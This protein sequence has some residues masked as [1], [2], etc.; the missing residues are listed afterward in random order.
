MCYESGWFCCG[1]CVGG[2]LCVLGKASQLLFAGSILA[3]INEMPRDVHLLG[4][5]ISSAI[6]VLRS[7]LVLKQTFFLNG[8]EHRNTVVL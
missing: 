8:F 4:R 7:S 6:S 5:K 3:T 1:H 2:H